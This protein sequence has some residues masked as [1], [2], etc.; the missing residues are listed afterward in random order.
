MSIDLN[1]NWMDAQDWLMDR[2]E[3]GQDLFTTAH[4]KA[5]HEAQEFADEPSLDEMADVIMCLAGAA[6]QRGW[7]LADV[8]GALRDKVMVNRA[9]T[10]AMNEDGTWSHVKAG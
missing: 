3:A 9:R 1:E 8:A 10:W 5:V 4:L 6:L 7:T 2:L